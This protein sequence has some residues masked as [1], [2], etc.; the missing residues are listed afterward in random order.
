MHGTLNLGTSTLTSYNSTNMEVTGKALE[1]NMHTCFEVAYP[2][3]ANTLF[4][5]CNGAGKNQVP[6]W[7]RI[8]E[9]AYGSAHG[10]WITKNLDSP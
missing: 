10:I 3:L 7:V 1:R 9:E 4:T 8:S 5:K 2:V 6:Q